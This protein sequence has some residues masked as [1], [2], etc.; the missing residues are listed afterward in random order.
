MGKDTLKPETMR[1]LCMTQ[2]A[3]SSAWNSE[4]TEFIRT[5]D[6][7]GINPFW[8]IVQLMRGHNGRLGLQLVLRVRLGRHV[9]VS[10]DL[11]PEQ[12]L[13]AA[14]V[15]GAIGMLLEAAGGMLTRPSRQRIAN[16]FSIMQDLEAQIVAMT[17]GKSDQAGDA[18]P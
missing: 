14:Q 18:W 10:P 15:P 5:A 9:A 13:A 7:A 1:V 6:T 3:G 11:L 2:A 12:F 17:E 16:W 8:A 4:V